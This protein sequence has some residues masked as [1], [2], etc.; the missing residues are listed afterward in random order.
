MPLQ[1]AVMRQVAF[2]LAQQQLL[3][4]E[5]QLQA[6]TAQVCLLR[7]RHLEAVM[8]RLLRAEVQLRLPRVRAWQQ[9]A[10]DTQLHS[11]TM[12]ELGMPP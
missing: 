4:M 11:A 9:Q 10:L 1:L 5:L 3:P 6:H 12:R 8:Q 2:L 7:W